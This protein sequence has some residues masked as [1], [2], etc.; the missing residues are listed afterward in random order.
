MKKLIAI[1]LL[2]VLAAGAAFAQPNGYGRIRT[3]FGAVIPFEDEADISWVFQPHA[4]IGL[5]GSNDSVNYM[6][7]ADFNISSSSLN[8]FGTWRANATVKL[9]ESAA[10]SVGKNELPWVQFSSLA[11]FGNQNDGFGASASTVNP[12]IR[13]DM[14]GAYLGL[15]SGNGIIHESTTKEFPVPGF[16][17]GYD[18]KAEKF[19]VGAAFAGLY[20]TRTIGTG[21]AA[22]EHDI[23]SWMGKAHAKFNFSPVVIGVNAAFYGAPQY[24]FFNLNPGADRIQN[25]KDAM[26][27]EAMLDAAISLEPC[28]IGITGAILM[29]VAEEDKGGGGSALRAGLSATFNLGGGFRL[30]P[31]VIYTQYLKGTGGADIESQTLQAGITFLFGF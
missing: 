2:M 9:A 28:V 13:F 26:V 17:L 7:Q 10:L 29:N 31:G 24:G 5:R 22:E 27:L 25:G 30:I 1:V 3:N 11:I 15:S 8:V 6:A 19:S 21:E 20:G 12:Y 18:Y 14:M 23:F 4:R 16:F